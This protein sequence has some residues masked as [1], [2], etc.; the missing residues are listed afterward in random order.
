M[1]GS[2]PPRTH[3]SDA[4]GTDNSAIAPVSLNRLLWGAVRTGQRRRLDG[5]CQASEKGWPADVAEL[6]DARDLKSLDLRSYGFDSRRPHQQHSDR[7][8]P[9][10]RSL[11]IGFSFKCWIKVIIFAS[12]AYNLKSYRFIREGFHRQTSSRIGRLSQVTRERFD[13]P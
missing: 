5:L 3:P 1:G 2:N 12:N 9:N 6:V 11:R 13:N 8:S 7:Q 10:P 4:R